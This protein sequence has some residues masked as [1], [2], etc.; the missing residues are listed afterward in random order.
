MIRLILILSVVLSLIIAMASQGQQ[1]DT[2]EHGAPSLTTRSSKV[3][4]FGEG[5]VGEIGDMQKKIG[6]MDDPELSRKLLPQFTVSDWTEFYNRKL[7]ELYSQG[8]L[9]RMAYSRFVL[10]TESSDHSNAVISFEKAWRILLPRDQLYW[11]NGRTWHVDQFVKAEDR[12]S[13][14]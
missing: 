11:N 1:R 9:S 5:W 2:D 8:V 6:Y 4:E 3:E 12:K 10:G 7:S 13:V 14:V